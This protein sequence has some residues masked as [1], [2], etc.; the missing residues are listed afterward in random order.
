MRDQSQLGD[1]E[2]V[3]MKSGGFTL[4][5]FD[6]SEVHQLFIYPLLSNQDRVQIIDLDLNYPGYCEDVN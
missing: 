2:T 4:L 1:Y 5:I 3:I 6:Q